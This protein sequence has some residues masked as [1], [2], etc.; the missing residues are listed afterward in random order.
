MQGVDSRHNDFSQ[1][2]ST[3]IGTRISLN[4][5]GKNDVSGFE[6]AALKQTHT[7]RKVEE[8]GRTVTHIITLYRGEK[9]LRM[10]K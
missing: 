10:H 1:L 7:N 5:A 4:V 8:N 9:H 6:G 2:L 3:L